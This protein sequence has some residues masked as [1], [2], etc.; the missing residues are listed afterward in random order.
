ML[1][2]NCLELPQD[3]LNEIIQRII[4]LK[5]KDAMGACLNA[6]G[7]LQ[8]EY[9]PLFLCEL[10]Q[11]RDRRLVPFFME[12]VRQGEGPLKDCAESALMRLAPN[13]VLEWEAAFAERRFLTAFASRDRFA[14][15]CTLT[16]L[17]TSG[18]TKPVM[19]AQHFLLCFNHS[20]IKEYYYKKYPGYWCYGGDIRL[21]KFM[22]EG[23]SSYDFQ[24]LTL[25]EA[26]ALL[27][28]AYGQNIRFNSQPAAGI[29]DY[30]QLL[31]FETEDLVRQDLLHKFYSPH[32]SAR[33]VGN[34]YLRALKNMDAALLYDFSSK[35]R[36][37]SLGERSQ[38]ILNYGE[39]FKNHTFLRTQVAGLEKE[40]GKVLLSAFVI[41]NTPQDEIIKISYELTL[42]KEKGYYCVAEFRETGRKELAYSDPENPLNYHVFCSA[43]RI[44]S[45][46]KIRDWLESEKEVLLTGE[47]ERGCCYKWLTGEQSS[48][49]SYDITDG[50]AVEFILRDRELLIYA[51]N[52]VKLAQMEKRIKTDLNLQLALSDKYY[53]PVQDVYRTVVY[54]TCLNQ[55]LLENYCDG[56]LRRMRGSWAVFYVEDYSKCLRL[57]QQRTINRL[58]LDNSTWY[59]WIK[60]KISSSTLMAKQV[61][62]YLDGCWVKVNVFN[63]TVEEELREL[64]VPVTKVIF[65]SEL[66]NYYDL[67]TPPVSE[68]R[69]WEIYKELHRMQKESIIGRMGFLPRLG[70]IAEKLGSVIIS[71]RMCPKAT[72][73]DF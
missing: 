67:F 25:L 47:F 19:E 13:R 23:G 62:Y 30:G 18:E 9:K 31:Q 69:K 66:E 40:Q 15:K 39:E 71:Q 29:N 32:L 56:S 17:W 34:I 6:L 27:Q 44:S 4:K 16:V 63:G 33:M 72:I 22:A 1:T 68:E 2:R 50:I 41:V 52:P 43:Y 48:G 38:F 65:G 49:G 37:A 42:V 54:N 45:A 61:E 51:K 5:P 21:S 73:F 35:E 3:F 64:D 70:E 12:V 20:G 46:K 26:A 24:E 60:D 7:Q 36:Q 57:L 58:Q 59:F 10:S 8:E 53:L 11:T 14:G 55:V 28:D